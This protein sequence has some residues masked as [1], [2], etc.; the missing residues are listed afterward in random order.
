MAAYVWKKGGI[1]VE[2]EC[3]EREREM[4]EKEEYVQMKV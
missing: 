4:E 2:R 3:L 1:L